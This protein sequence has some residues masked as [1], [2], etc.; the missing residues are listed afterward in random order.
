M[1]TKLTVV[2]ETRSTY[3]LHSSFLT[4]QGEGHHAGRRAVFLRFS[5]C[6]VWNGLEADRERDA[7]FNAPCARICDTEFFGVDVAKGGGAYDL[8]ALVERTKRLW[9]GGPS[10]PFIVLTGGEPSLQVTS[11]LIDTFHEEMGAY[12]AIETNGSMPVPLDTD[13]VTLSPKPPMRVLTRDYSEVKCL[14]PLFDPADFA[15]LSSRLWV[16]P[17]DDKDFDLNVQR[18]AAYVR[19]YPNWRLGAQLHKLWRVA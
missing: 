5:G 19:R 11:E 2:K 14:F 18:A 15:P 17:V 10:R 8:K 3:V 1:K 6:N 4:I 13:W 16:Q 7:T 9:D 12:V